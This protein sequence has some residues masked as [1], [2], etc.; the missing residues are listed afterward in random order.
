MNFIN[1]F[2]ELIVNYDRARKNIF[3]LKIN[4]FNFMALNEV[5]RENWLHAFVAL[6]E[7][8]G[9]VTLKFRNFY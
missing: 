4:F 5:I 6:Y 3:L 2:F 7:Y 1:M 8:E 9:N